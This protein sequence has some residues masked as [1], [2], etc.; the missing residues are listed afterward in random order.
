MASFNRVILLGNL[1]RDPE[2]RYTPQGSAVCEFGLALNEVYKNKNTGQTTEKVHFIDVTCWGRTAEI[3]SEYLKKG[4]QAHVEGKLTQDRWQDEASGQN[5][6]KVKVTCEHLTLVGRKS[7][8]QGG[9][10][11]EGSGG[12]ASAQVGQEEDIPF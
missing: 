4:S 3:A 1:T 8:S 12:G 7:D 6:S 5:R 2:L 10:S 9:G 11:S